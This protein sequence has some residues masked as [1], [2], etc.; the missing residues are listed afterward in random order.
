MENSVYTP[1]ESD[2]MVE[3]NGIILASRSKR[4]CASFLDTIVLL[5]FILPLMYFTGGFEA[6]MKGEQ[7]SITYTLTFGLISL[8][9]YAAINGYSLTK[10]GQTIGKKLLRIKLVT[11]NDELPP[12]KTL[13]MRYAVFFLPGQVPLVGQIFGIVNCLFIFGSQRRCIHDYAAKTKVV[14]C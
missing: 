8:I 2:L 12:I 4:L 3:E 1:P 11:L 7:Q 5:V 13:I 14:N 10:M 6:P 9:I